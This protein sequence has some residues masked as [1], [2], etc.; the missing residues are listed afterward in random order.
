M[1]LFTDLPASLPEELVQT[2][3]STPSFRVER[4]IS[5]GHASPEGFWYDQDSH[6]WVLL[7]QGAARLTLEAREP[8]DMLPGAFI[9]IPAHTR[10][11]VDW[12][13]PTQ[14][15]CW[16]AIHYDGQAEPKP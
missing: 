11:R 15:T 12:T 8:I 3:L 16:L 5:R 13:D 2:L 1:N 14:P 4:I 7:L 10:H 6:E 9:N